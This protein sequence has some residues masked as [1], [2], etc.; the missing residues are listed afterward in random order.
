M[1][2]FFINN[3]GNHPPIPLVSF[4]ENKITNEHPNYTVDARG[5]VRR[6]H[7]KPLPRQNDKLNFRKLERVAKYQ[8]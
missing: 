3:F 7:P 2:K 4:L 8:L 5:T 6:K 1:Y